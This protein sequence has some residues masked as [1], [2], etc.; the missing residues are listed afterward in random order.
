M[1]ISGPFTDVVIKHFIV[2]EVKS[3]KAVLRWRNVRLPWREVVG[4][5]FWLK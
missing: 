4:M 5:P 2:P 1:Y 3:R